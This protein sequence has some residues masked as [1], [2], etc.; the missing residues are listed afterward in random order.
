MQ[1]LPRGDAEIVVKL[2]QE[3]AITLFAALGALQ[4]AWA[5][6]RLDGRETVVVDL[7]QVSAAYTDQ[8]NKLFVPFYQSLLAEIEAQGNAGER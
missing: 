6:A 2:S 5:S 4:S 1:G 3:N 8:G 7:R